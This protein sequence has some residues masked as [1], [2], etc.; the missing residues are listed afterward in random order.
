MN[1]A[2]C[3]EGVSLSMGMCF[4]GRLGA[5]E[6]AGFLFSCGAHGLSGSV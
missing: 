4:C 1:G 2:T 3:E 6:D 5:A